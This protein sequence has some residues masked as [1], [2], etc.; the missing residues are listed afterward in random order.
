MRLLDIAASVVGFAAWAQAW[1]TGT[2]VDSTVYTT[3]VVP[4]YTT[5]C[6]E[7]TTFA[8]KNITYTVTKPT[9]ITIT[10]CPCTLSIHKPP[11][12]TTTT[13]YTI[14][15]PNNQTTTGFHNTTVT[16]A[17][18]TITPP[19]TTDL[20]GETPITTTPSPTKTPVGPTSTPTGNNPPPLSV[21]AADRMGFSVLG[22]LLAAVAVL[23]LAL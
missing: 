5:Y 1:G 15:P 6:P 13:T 8:Y 12:V 21:S 9:T 20:Q 18:L 3:I 11:P 16:T 22:S 4:T 10:N 2:G 19:P 23:A 14:P 7:P 17:T